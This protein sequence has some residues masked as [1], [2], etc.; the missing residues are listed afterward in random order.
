VRS[1]LLQQY[2]CRP[3]RRVVL[4]RQSDLWKSVSAVVLRYYNNPYYY[5]PFY[6]D[7]FYYRPAYVYPRQYYNTGMRTIRID[8]ATGLDGA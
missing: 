3:Y 5:D 1:L 4:V 7:P 8:M 6:Y 2:Y